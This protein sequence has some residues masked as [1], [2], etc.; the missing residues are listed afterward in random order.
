M[1]NLKICVVG[2][3]Y[4][5]LP[6]AAIFSSKGIEVIAVDTKK[7]VV[8]T[9][10]KGNIHIEEP[11][12][13]ELVKSVVK[14]GHLKCSTVPQ[15]ADTYIICVP[16]PNLDDKYKSCDLKYVMSAIDSIVPILKK[17]DLIIVE[18]TIAPR[19]MEDVVKPVLESKGFAI[20]ED[21]YLAHC[22][23]RVLPGQILNEMINNN[24]IIGG[25]TEKCT[26]KAAEVYSKIVEGEIIKTEAKT[27]EMSKLVENTYR[28]V[29]IAF[30]NELTKVCNDLQINVLDVINMANKH[31]RVNIL[32][33]GPGVGG[34]CLAVD[35]YFICSKSPEYSNIISM[36][37]ST[38]KSMP[39]YVVSGVDSI[40]N[41]DY[42]KKILVLGVTYKPN[43]DDM[44]ESP[45][46]EIACKLID[47][48]YDVNVYD[49]HTKDYKNTDISNLNKY[50]LVLC[51][52]SHNEFKKMSIPDNVAIFDV[53]GNVFDKNKTIN[54]GNL[55]EYTLKKRK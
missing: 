46:Y 42:S 7:E 26:E 5:G 55:Y 6:T 50:D 47:A 24:R 51:L 34:H 18:S 45:S 3:G 38:N 28:D 54:Y 22:P 25:I 40:L 44:R 48:G 11:G 33:P 53:T 49:P 1:I 15:V 36:S 21:L 4:I 17:G 19:T 37:R 35:P 39:E 41:N 23:E 20:G 13:G 31:P 9:I 12:L 52:V 27:A 29:N 43:V 14:S 8:D 30:A 2:L 16:T 32:S 10:N